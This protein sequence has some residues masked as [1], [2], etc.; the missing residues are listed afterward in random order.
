MILA[1][2]STHPAAFEQALA[3]VHAAVSTVSPQQRV[4]APPPQG[5]PPVFVAGPDLVGEWSG[6][7][8]TYQRTVPMRIMIRADGGAEASIDDQA[9]VPVTGLG[10]DNGRLTGGAALR[11]PTDDAAR[12]PHSVTFALLLRAGRLAGEVTANAIADRIYYAISSYAELTR[13]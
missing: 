3:I 9:A 8:R 11:I 10:F 7:L 12:W 4:G 13:R 2:T 5:A 6:T 1:N